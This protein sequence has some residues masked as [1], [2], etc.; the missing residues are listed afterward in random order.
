MDEEPVTL[1]RAEQ[2]RALVLNQVLEGRMTQGEAALVL[3]VSVRQAKRLTARYRAAGPA[4]LVHGNRG[5]RPWQAVAPDVAARVVALAGGRYAGLNQQHLTEKLAAEEGIVLGRTTVR[6]LLARA[7]LSTPRPRRAPVARRRRERMA[8]EGLL[9]QAD[10]SRHRWLGPDGPELTL[11]AMIDDATGTVLGAVFREQ[12]D[13]VGY[14]LLLEEIVRS[15]GIPHAL[16]VDR[17]SI[18]QQ[19]QRAPLTIAEELAGGRAPTQVGRALGELGIRHIAAHSPQAKGRVERLWGTLQSRLVAELALAGVRTLEQA[20]RFLADY[21]PQHNARFAVPPTDPTPAY[22]PVPADLN[23]A[24]VF[25]FKQTRVVRAD[26]TI[27]YEGRPLQLLGT[28]A[29]RGWAR[30]RVEVHERLDGQRVIVHQGQEIPSRPAPLEAAALRARSVMAPRPPTKPP[31][32]VRPPPASHP[33]RRYREVT[34]SA[35]S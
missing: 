10:G 3:G 9:L 28:P 7:G 15:R 30:A 4:G 6:R 33:W 17:H 23:L 14:L 20:N 35:V 26:N 2:R 13:G 31:T 29:R 16:Y 1:G 21:L 32:P 25:C 12:E 22:R 34:Q 11:I 8:Q 24:H 27:S 19:N 5:R 18:F